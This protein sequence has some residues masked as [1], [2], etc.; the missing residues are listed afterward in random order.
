MTSDSSD[1]AGGVGLSLLSSGLVQPT[2]TA[3]KVN[4]RNNL[5]F[6][7]YKLKYCDSIKSLA[8]QTML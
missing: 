1:G 4:N 5:F 7:F 8:I 3:N 2:A 6:I